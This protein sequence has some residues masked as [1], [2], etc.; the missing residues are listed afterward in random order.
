MKIK[1][2]KEWRKDG[3]SPHY[4]VNEIIDALLAEVE[5]LQDLS[6]EA[7]FV[8]TKMS[9]KLTTATE[10]LKNICVQ[11]SAGTPPMVIHHIAAHALNAIGATSNKPADEVER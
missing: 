10:A 6:D 3:G 5:V 9:R 8:V 2:I 1:E 7:G 4:H 11:I